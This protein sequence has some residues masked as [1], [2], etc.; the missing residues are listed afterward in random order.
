MHCRAP[1]RKESERVWVYVY[2]Q[3]RPPRCFCK[4]VKCCQAPRSLA[5]TISCLLWLRQERR[6]RM[7]RAWIDVVD[8]LPRGWLFGVNKSR[9]FDQGGG[10]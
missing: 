9:C 8:E 4:L 6:H 1:L 5:A 2:I 10:K 7:H 3:M